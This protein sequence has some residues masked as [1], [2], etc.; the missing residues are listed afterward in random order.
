M[1]R[2]KAPKKGFFK[3]K[4]PQKYSGNPT[5]IIFRSDWERHFMTY[6]DNHP[7]VLSWSSEE[8]Y[9]RYRCPVTNRV[10]R[11]FPDFK[12]TFRNKQG[13][14]ETTVFEI[15]PLTQT[16]PPKRKS[17]Y[18]VEHAKTYAVNQAKW[19]AAKD[20]CQRRNLKFQILTEKELFGK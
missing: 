15:K 19:E 9:I 11:Y 10:R 1:A 14:V 20:Y 3:P 13:E 6:L 12:V 2:N 5:Q 18:F 16:Q 4:N 17:K 7:D 8:I